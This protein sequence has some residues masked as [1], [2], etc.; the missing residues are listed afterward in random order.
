[1]GQWA[2]RTHR[3]GMG[4]SGRP[5]YESVIADFPHR[6]WVNRGQWIGK[7]E[8]LRQNSTGSVFVS[9]EQP[10]HMQV[11]VERTLLGGK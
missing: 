9:A 10:G 4:R 5:G 6:E 11:P 3:T 7:R 1:M 2:Q 8:E